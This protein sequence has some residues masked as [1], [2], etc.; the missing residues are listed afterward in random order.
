MLCYAK[1]HDSLIPQHMYGIAYSIRLKF[2]GVH[3]LAKVSLKIVSKFKIPSNV[4]SNQNPIQL[5]FQIKI[6][7]KC[8]EKKKEI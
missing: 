8:E 3:I 5:L 1:Y 7:Y 4:I 6:Q 2:Y